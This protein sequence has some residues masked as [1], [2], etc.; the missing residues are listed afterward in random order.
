[1]KPVTPFRVFLVFIRVFVIFIAFT[2]D[3]KVRADVLIQNSVGQ[4]EFEKDGRLL[5]PEIHGKVIEPVSIQTFAH[6]V[7]KIK[8]NSFFMGLGEQSLASIESAPI[9]TLAWGTFFIAAPREDEPWLTVKTPEGSVTTAGGE[10]IITVR[11]NKTTVSVVSGAV[12]IKDRASGHVANLKAG[13]A[14]WQGGLRAQ[15]E[16]AR[17][18]IEALDLSPVL[19]SVKNLSLLSSDE[20]QQHY[21]SLR[22]LWKQAIEAVAQQ[23]QDQVIGDMQIYAEVKESERKR[24]LATKRRERQNRAEFRAKFLVSPLKDTEDPSESDRAPAS[25]DE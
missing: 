12:A 24:A 4:I 8:V 25:S 3:V 5:K 9:V 15:G 11:S 19:T 2:I 20:W 18:A 21:D 1:M 7:S 17:G 23:N 14:L 16:R 10:F 6:S 22:P 13:Y